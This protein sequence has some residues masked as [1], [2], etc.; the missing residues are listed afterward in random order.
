MKL[1][2]NE[3]LSKEIATILKGFGEPVLQKIQG[4]ADED[5]LAN[6]IV[7]VLKVLSNKPDERN[8]PNVLNGPTI[9]SSDGNP[10][11]DLSQTIPDINNPD[12]VINII[13]DL[14]LNIAENEPFPQVNPLSNKEK[15]TLATKN[16]NKNPSLFSSLKGKF[17]SLLSGLSENPK[18]KVFTP[19]YTIDP[20]V[21]Y[22]CQDDSIKRPALDDKPA[23]SSYKALEEPKNEEKK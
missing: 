12:Y 13:L 18:V 2:D 21:K 9:V 7:Q 5:G 23:C 17:S 10:T 4:G 19:T 22:N 20:D 8:G 11:K 3:K 14:I 1:N 6:L 16:D 15:V